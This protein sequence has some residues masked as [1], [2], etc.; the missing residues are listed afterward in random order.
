MARYTLQI[1]ANKR[2][3][4]LYWAYLQL[5][6]GIVVL[7]LYLF[8]DEESS[9]ARVSHILIAFFFISNGVSGI[10]ALR[11]NYYVEINDVY[12]EWLPQFPGAYVSVVVW[13]DIRWIKQEN[14][15]SITFSQQ[16]SFSNTL[17]LTDFPVV[18]KLQIMRELY[19]IASAKQLRLINFEEMVSAMA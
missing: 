8:F 10:R 17:R 4:K 6:L 18:D 15:G 19:S 16:S 14:D 11:R 9:F 1:E 3:K 13:D 5:V 2:R 12:I 7:T